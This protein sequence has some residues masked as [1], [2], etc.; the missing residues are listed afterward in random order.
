MRVSH[1]FRNTLELA[2]GVLRG[3]IRT[4]IDL[5][6]VTPNVYL[7]APNSVADSVSPRYWID[8]LFLL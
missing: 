3:L 7:K 8:R 2:D 5:L 4:I 6:V 1:I